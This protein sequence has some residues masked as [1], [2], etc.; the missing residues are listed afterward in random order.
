MDPRETAIRLRFSS[1]KPILDEQGRRHFAAAEALAFGRGG[2][3]L[4]ARITG[5]VRSTIGRGLQEIKTDQ[6]AGQGR[7]RKPGGGRKKKTE[8]DLTLL[9]DLK[10]LVDPDTRGDPMQPLLWTTRSLRNLSVA[11]K[12][13]KHD[14]SLPVIGKALRKMGYSLQANVKTKEGGSHPD[15]NAQF[16]YL[17]AQVKDFLASNDPVL[18]VDTKKKELVGDFK[19]NGRE[20]REKGVPDCVKVHDFIDPALGRAI[21]YGIYD[22]AN[23]QGWVSVGNDHDTSAFAVNAIRRWWQQM[24]VIRFSHAKRLLITAD[25]GGSNG[26]RVRLWKV[27]LQKLSFELGIPITVC[28]LPPGTSKWN[29][30]EHRLFSF[31]TINWRGKPLR[32]YQTIVQLISNTTTKTGLKVHAELDTNIYPKGIVVSDEQLDALYL[33]RHTF[34]GDWNYTLAPTPDI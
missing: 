23:N 2:V 1:L 29:K 20:W 6:Q 30:I 19:N 12:T 22:V 4:V 28:H 34:H 13:L 15:R 18:S 7:I 5:I 21:P 26:S 17:N 16:D 33:T 24:G 11:L 32:C 27:E 9:S 3:S 25:G 31:I 8:E 14:V 10:T